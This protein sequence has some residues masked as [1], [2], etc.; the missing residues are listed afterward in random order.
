MA[1]AEPSGMEPRAFPPEV[2]G[3][4]Q[5]LAGQD[6]LLKEQYLDFLRLR[7][8]RQTLLARDSRAPLAESEP[9]HDGAFSRPRARDPWTV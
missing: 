3:V 2:A 8:F 1:E 6:V 4:L 7:R 5:G 9:R